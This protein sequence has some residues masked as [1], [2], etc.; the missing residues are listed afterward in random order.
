M[1]FEE[2]SSGLVRL[3]EHGLVIV[4]KHPWRLACTDEG[5]QVIEPAMR[6]NPS[7]LQVCR[8]VEKALSVDPWKPGEQLPSPANSLRYPGLTK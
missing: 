3:V 1:N 5:R 8:A 4:E 7:G 6:D 2:L